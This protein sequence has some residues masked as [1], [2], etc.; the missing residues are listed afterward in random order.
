MACGDDLEVRVRLDG[1][2]EGRLYKGRSI[3]HGAIEAIVDIAAIA[4]RM[5]SISWVV[6]PTRGYEIAYYVFA[7][8]HKGVSF[9]MMS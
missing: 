6:L 4:E 5:V 2:V 7:F 9:W 8:P 3:H 1:C